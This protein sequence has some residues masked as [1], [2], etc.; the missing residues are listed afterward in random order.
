VMN[1]GTRLVLDNLSLQNNGMFH[2]IAGT[3]LFTGKTNTFI[4]GS[5]APVF[6]NL[7]LDKPSASLQLQ[8][9]IRV[10]NQLQFT[11]GLLHLNGNNI[12]LVPTALLTGENETSYIAAVSGGYVEITKTLNAPSAENP[13]NLGLVISS[14]QNLGP[15]TIRRGQSLLGIAAGNGS[16]L[17]YFDVSP[18]NNTGL[19]ATLRFQYLDA[20]LNGLNEND[21]TTWTSN[22]NAGWTSLGEASRNTAGNYVEQTGI[23]S[24]SRFT[25]AL[26]S[27]KW[28]SFNTECTGSEV[29]I[30]WKSEVDQTA[31]FT[32]RRSTDSRNWTIIGTVPASGKRTASPDYYFVDSQAPSGTVY[33]QVQQNNPDDRPRLSPVLQNNCGRQEELNVFPNPVQ[34][35]CWV[36]VRSENTTA[37]VLRIYDHKGA[38]VQQKREIIQKGN[39][40]F[41]LSMMHLAAGTYALIISWTDGK[42]KMKRLEKY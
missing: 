37:I 41:E 9:G 23:N 2:Q 19:N 40:Q 29:R 15:V 5:S 22:N 30:R 4:S 24:F 42:T 33:Y 36:Q 25:L 14:P 35:N 11:N 31:S 1:P 27:A 34:Q 13:G 8:T 32:V 16:I 38:L 20:E 26:P 39:N 18:S 21:L 17:R 28:S 6:Y 7:Q 12:V 10:N 3:V